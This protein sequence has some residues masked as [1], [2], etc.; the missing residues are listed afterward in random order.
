MYSCTPRCTAFFWET[1]S[2]VINVI[3]RWQLYFYTVISRERLG[4]RFLSFIDFHLI[5]V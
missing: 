5:T 1:I 4:L 3:P 2:G